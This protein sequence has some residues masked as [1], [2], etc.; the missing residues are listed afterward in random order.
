MKVTMRAWN[1]PAKSWE[2]FDAHTTRTERT[3]E[4]TARFGGRTARGLCCGV[5]EGTGTWALVTRRPQVKGAEIYLE[6]NVFHVV[7]TR[8]QLQEAVDNSDYIDSSGESCLIC[9]CLVRSG[10]LHEIDAT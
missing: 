3:Q 9:S 5:L 1:K 4:I 2:G 8:D 7:K 6:G 10:F